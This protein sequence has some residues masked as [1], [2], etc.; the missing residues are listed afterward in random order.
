MQATRLNY[1]VT[2]V[3]QSSTHKALLCM[4]L[5]RD[6]KNVEINNIFLHFLEKRQV[7]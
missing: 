7:P 4:A 3:Y 1:V 2:N 5:N 6:S